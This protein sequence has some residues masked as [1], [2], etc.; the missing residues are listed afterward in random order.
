MV[1]KE[2]TIDPNKQN[3]EK[4]TEGADNK[5]LDTSKF[6]VTW[7]VNKLIKLIFNSRMAD[8]S[9]NFAT[10]NQVET[11]LDLAKKKERKKIKRLICVISLIKITSTMID[12]KII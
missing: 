5:I 6:I 4:K 9:K 12:C 2:D 10:K 11:A 8:T 7:D 3:L 1:I